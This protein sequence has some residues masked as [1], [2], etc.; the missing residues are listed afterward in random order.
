MAWRMQRLSKMHDPEALTD[1]AEFLRW[2][3]L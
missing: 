2:E 3:G 1:V